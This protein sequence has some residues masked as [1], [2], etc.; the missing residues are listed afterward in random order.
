[1]SSH[2]RYSVTGFPRRTFPASRCWSTAMLVKSF[3]IE[4]ML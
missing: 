3:E 4:Q 2:G 1:M